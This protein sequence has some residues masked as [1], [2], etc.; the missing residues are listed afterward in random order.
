M[1]C[2]ICA[3]VTLQATILDTNLATQQCP[4]CEGLFI[5]SADYWT[6]RQQHGPDLPEQSDPKP[7]LPSTESS[8]AKQCPFC[9][10]LLLPYKIA[11]DIPFTVDHCGACNGMWFDQ[12]E[13]NSLQR[14]NLH[15]NLHQMF[16]EPWQRR[17]REAEHRMR[18]DAIYRAKFG[19]A[20]YAEVRRVKA[21][22]DAHP[23]RQALRA[24]LNAE[25][26]IPDK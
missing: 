25:Q 20:D 12:E 4:R 14:R 15:D 2:P 16:S 19:E 9:N 10:H 17:L 23:Q 26:G 7:T 3:P 18:M 8:R 11:L 1:Q 22:L 24:Y 5:S 21:W 13:W 6:W